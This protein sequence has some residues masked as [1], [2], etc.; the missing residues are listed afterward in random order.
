M[1][2]V[3]ISDTH[4][5]HDQV[6]VPNGDLLIHAG[7]CT[8][9]IGQKSL[10]S[11]LMWMG[12]QPHEHKVL[13]AGNH[14]GAF[15]LWGDLAR[16]MVKE[17]APGVVYLQDERHE[18]NG[19]NIWGSPVTPSFCNWHFNRERGEVIRRHWDFI[20][21][22]TDILVTH[23]PARYP[24]T[25]LDVSGIDNEKVGCR[26]L[27]DA[28]QRVMPE[29]HVFGHIHHGYGTG[30]YFEDNGHKT[31]LINASICNE[32]YEPINKPLIYIL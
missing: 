3:C 17:V 16:A 21:D 11:F 15:E 23:G 8:D 12:K 7:D 32:R 24:G 30:K 19:I 25:N 27:Y 6:E 20:P 2:I 31:V 1:R 18:I 29:L 26:D 9:D 10:R 28:V 14:D 5:M 13:I 22:D 4:G